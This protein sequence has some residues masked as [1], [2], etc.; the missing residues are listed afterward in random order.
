MQGKHIVI[1]GGG[2]GVGAAL[3]KA[4]D[5][6]GANVTVTGRREEP[7]QIIA[8]QLSRGQAICADVTDRESVRAML[9]TARVRFGNIDIVIA[10]AG[11]VEST[12]FAKM[13]MGQWQDTLAVNLTGTFNLF[14]EALA[15]MQQKQWG[16]MIAVASMA[17]LKGYQ[18]VSAY[19]AAKHAVIGLVRSLALE[20]AREGITVNALCPGFTETP[21]LER[22]LE[23][24]VN[25]TAMTAEQAAATLNKD[26]PMGRFIQP[27]EVAQTALYLCGCGAASINGQA[28]AI[29]GGE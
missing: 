17:G 27:E 3:A 20:Y 28:I 4:F 13:T 21:M 14:Q 11:A 15:D 2:T 24:I 23:N 29:S 7:L 6:A 25:K 1:T 8:G 22:S 18:Y 26:N 19:C 12:P 9:N 16:R 10:N 5:L